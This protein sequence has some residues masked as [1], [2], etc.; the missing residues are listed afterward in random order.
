MGNARNIAFWVVLFLLV[1]ALF[2]LFSGGGT[3]LQ[4]REISY[5]DFVAA[6]ENKTVSSVTLD[7]EQVRFRSSDGNDYVTIKPE[8]AEVTNMLVTNN[9]PVRA[10][11]QQQSGFQSFLLSLLPFL[12]LIGVWIYFM[13]RMQGGG[14]GGAMGFGKSKAKMLTEKHGR[15]TFDDVA[16]ID[17]AKEELEEIVEFLHNPQKFSRLG[18]K[19]PKGALLVGPPG[20]GKTL[21]ARA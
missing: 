13:N 1:L 9:I 5:T 21:L 7:G 20:T 18:G 19:I 10:E 14:K 6:V 3:T 12:L 17:E 11:A 15:V 16:G 4:S 2:N 8:D